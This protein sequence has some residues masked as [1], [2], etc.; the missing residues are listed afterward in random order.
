MKY[1]NCHLLF[2]VD[3]ENME[4]LLYVGE[5]EIDDQNKRHHILLC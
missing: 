3:K 1:K 4:Y 2:E 5:E